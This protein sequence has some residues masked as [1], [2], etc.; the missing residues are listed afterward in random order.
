MVL[1]LNQ[2][3]VYSRI[4]ISFPDY[5]P[6][7]CQ[8]HSHT[9]RRIDLLNS[10]GL[11]CS[12]RRPRVSRLQICIVYRIYLSTGRLFNT[13]CSSSYSTSLETI[14]GEMPITFLQLSK[15]LYLYSQAIC[16]YLST[17][18]TCAP[19]ALAQ[20]VSRDVQSRRK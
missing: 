8:P 18:S 2:V 7:I 17:M 4:I 13:L 11:F 10:A 3:N 6:C 19:P 5:Y 9:G 20:S 14:A 1:L 12:P 16:I 15:E